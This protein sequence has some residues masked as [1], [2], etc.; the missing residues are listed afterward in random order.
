MVHAVGLFTGSALLGRLAC[1]TVLHDGTG[2]TVIII[3][4]V[5]TRTAGSTLI[6]SI[7]VETFGNEVIASLTS[8]GVGKVVIYTLF[9][10]ILIETVLALRKCRAFRTLSTIRIVVIIYTFAASFAVLANLAPLYR[11]GA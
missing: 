3:I 1:K 10:V 4:N 11:T 2:S 6:L 7:T 9:T 5:E 8:A